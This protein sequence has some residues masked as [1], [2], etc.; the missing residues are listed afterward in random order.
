MVLVDTSVWI[1]THRSPDSADARTLRS[2]LDGDDVS[3][4]L[5]VRIE[6]VAAAPKKDRNKLRRALSALPLVV[7]TEATWRVVEAW[8]ARARDAGYTFA[9]TDLLIGALASELTGLVWS[10]DSD[11]DAME[12]LGFVHCY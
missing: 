12:K 11:F 9:L 2:L 3:L 4:P 5:P 8:T 7:P 10:L 1:A 6:F